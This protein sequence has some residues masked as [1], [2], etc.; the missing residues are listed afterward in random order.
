M[1]S[2]TLDYQVSHLALPATEDRYAL[3]QKIAQLV[4]DGADV[5]SGDYRRNF[6]Y[7]VKAHPALP[8]MDFIT[9]RG[10]HLGPHTNPSP[11]QQTLAAG[12]SLRLAV[13]L[14]I[15]RK[16]KIRSDGAR[17]PALRVPTNHY[18]SWLATKLENAGFTLAEAQWGDPRFHNI[19]KPSERF[20]LPSLAYIA[21][22]TVKDPVLA[23]GAFLQGIGR[24][25]AF[26][27]GLLEVIDDE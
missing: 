3:H 8:G 14:P 20:V 24:N 23:A 1:Q 5:P 6:L 12:Q 4:F 22:V 16:S 26:G 21:R 9:L 15:Y 18:H 10:T 25:K 7:S 13:Q 17:Q 2:I 27:F 11:E 19:D